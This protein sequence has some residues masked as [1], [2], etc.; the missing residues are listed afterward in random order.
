MVN[1]IRSALVF[2]VLGA[3]CYGAY[4]SLSA[5]PEPE[6]P[7]E[8]G[9]DWG[10]APS[11]ELPGVAAAPAAPP[12]TV[13]EAVP[14]EKAGGQ[15][16]A[17]EP[18]P[19][20][21]ADAAPWAPD[22][23]QTAAG[24][25]SESLPLRAPTGSEPRSPAGLD[26]VAQAPSF[27]D[28]R[29]PGDELQ[30]MAERADATPG[31]GAASSR[32]EAPPAADPSEF[33]KIQADMAHVQEHL[34]Q[35]RLAQALRELSPYF[36]DPRL[37]PQQQAEINT[38]LDQLAGTVIYDRADHSLEPPYVVQAGETL[39]DIAERFSVPWQLLAN[40][41]GISDPQALA[42]GEQLKV[43]RGPFQAVID[44]NQQYLVLLVDQMYAGRFHIGTEPDENLKAGTFKVQA[45]RETPALDPYSPASPTSV[46]DEPAGKWVELSGGQR[47]QAGA[48]SPFVSRATRASI[49]LSSQDASNVHD[50][51]SVG[52][53]VRIIR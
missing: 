10:G 41:N 37:A 36:N 19:S 15:R 17:A 13:L 4:V 14:D 44:L 51:L 47:I 43:V 32:T 50:I 8:A 29:G 26:T 48:A 11:V 3:V 42:A 16:A 7:P 46:P 52:S 24:P 40:I 33:A 30:P 34:D 31:D 39:A 21:F 27:Q 18:D 38:L 1:T 23:A 12:A 45:R 2:V 6:P 49:L 35:E 53:E 25:G 22:P 20:Q 5:G 28:A 9:D